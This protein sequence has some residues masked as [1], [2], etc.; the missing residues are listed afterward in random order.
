MSKWYKA[1]VEPP[2]MAK[3]GKFISMGLESDAMIKRVSK[4]MYANPISGVREIVANELTAA[5]IAKQQGYNPEIHCSIQKEDIIIQGINSLGMTENIFKNV[6]CVLGRTTN[7]DGKTPGRFGLGRLAYTCLSDYMLLETKHRNG[8]SYSM[9]GVEGRGFQELNREPDIPYG[10]KISIAPSKNVAHLIHDFKYL[11][12]MIAWNS[13]IPIILKPN[14]NTIHNNLFEYANP[15]EYANANTKSIYFKNDDVEFVADMSSQTQQTSFLCGIPIK[16]T[17]TPQHVTP[18]SGNQIRIRYINIFD[19]LKF[20]STSDRERLSSTAEKAVNDLV[21]TEIKNYFSDRPKDLPGLLKDPRRGILYHLFPDSPLHREVRV[22]DEYIPQVEE[23]GR[24]FGSPILNCTIFKQAWI[25]PVLKRYPEARFVK[26]APEIENI[27][28]FLERKNI[29]EKISPV[30]KDK[31]A[32]IHSYMGNF[33][34]NYRTRVFSEKPVTDMMLIKLKDGDQLNRIKSFYRKFPS[35]YMFGYLGFTIYDD[36]PS[37]RNFEDIRAESLNHVFYTT[38]GELSGKELYKKLKGKTLFYS[39]R[40]AIVDHWFKDTKK[41]VVYCTPKEYIEFSLFI[42]DGRFDV[43]TYVN[44]DILYGPDNMA[45]LETY[46]R[47]KLD[48]LRR[49]IRHVPKHQLAEVSYLVGQEPVPHEE[50]CNCGK[51]PN[52]INTA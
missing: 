12:Q 6:Y 1:E 10:T 14:D 20:K 39:P 42:T 13:Q 27:K 29:T 25:Q 11:I 45:R 16:Y 49:L 37:L 2:I 36:I 24:L 5:R 28:D 41:I 23:I 17:Y 30:R 32:V 18:Y 34:Y 33:K 19:E 15:K 3:E 31:Y 52:K 8:D 48:I 40:K 51:C 35:G 9:L 4:D 21:E 7:N 22:Y 26:D 38:L 50:T 47:V 43:G 44:H 46:L